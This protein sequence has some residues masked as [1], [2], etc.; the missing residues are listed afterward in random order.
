MGHNLV[1]TPI[2]PSYPPANVYIDVVLTHKMKTSFSEWETI[3]VLWWA[4]TR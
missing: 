4:P 1:Y 2:N 3:G